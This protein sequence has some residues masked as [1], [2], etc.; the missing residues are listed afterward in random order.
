MTFTDGISVPEGPVLLDDNSWVIVEMGPDRGCVTQVSSD[1]KEKR[2]VARTGRPNGL[3]VDRDGVVWVAESRTPSLL[4][5]TL[6]GK[7][8]VFLTECDGEPFLFPNDLVFGPDGLLYMTDSGILFD[9]FAPGGEVRPNYDEVAIDGRVYRIDV[10]TRAIEKIDAGI[11]FTNGIVF[12]PDGCL[13]VNETITGAV[14]R[15]RWSSDGEIGP[16]EEFGNVIAPGGPEGLRGPDG[17]KFG[18]N[19]NL[20]VTVFGQGDV[21]VLGRDGDVVERIKTE[22]RLPTNCAFGPR[23]SKKLYVTE[24]E[25]G[26][27]EVFD[28]GTDGFPLY[29][30]EGEPAGG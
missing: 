22:G 28:V 27:L 26:A 4:R 6:D 19:G 15:Y 3:A 9:D 23:G 17:M 29:R 8:E 16:R 10:Q 7:Y 13:Y 24:D 18:E 20:Y 12:G 21:T 30:G 5:M 14:Y 11:R 25:R 2:M 1:G